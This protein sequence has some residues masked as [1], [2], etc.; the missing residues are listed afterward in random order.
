MKTKFFYSMIFVLG[1]VFAGS[2]IA[3]VNAQAAKKTVKTVQK[4]E[5]TCPE[6]PTVVSNKPGKCPKCGMALVEKKEVK[7]VVK[8]VTKMETK[9]VKK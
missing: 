8:K 7:K 2:T 1:L 9:Q 5:Y 4:V 3:N 6:H